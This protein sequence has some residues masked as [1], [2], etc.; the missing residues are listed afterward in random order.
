MSGKPFI[1]LFFVGRALFGQA[2]GA[3]P[4]NPTP[5]SVVKVKRAPADGAHQDTGSFVDH[6]D[7]DANVQAM[8]HSIE[9]SGSTSPT[10]NGLVPEVPTVDSQSTVP[11]GYRAPTDVT[12]SG[13]AQQAVQFSAASRAQKN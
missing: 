3:M 5:N 2:N 12:L 8:Q 13:T 10:P 7:F 11:P 1:V 9:N 6:F 4:T